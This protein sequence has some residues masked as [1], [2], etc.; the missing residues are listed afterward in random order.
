LIGLRRH[1]PLWCLGGNPA[2]FLFA[3]Q[4]EQPLLKGSPLIVLDFLADFLY[5]H[6]KH[7]KDAKK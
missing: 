5:S 4:I 7:N 3:G 2:G 1:L 6:I